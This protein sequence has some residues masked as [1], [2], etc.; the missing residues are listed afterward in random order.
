MAR[1]ARRLGMGAAGLLAVLPG[2]A[3]VA[4]TPYLRGT[5]AVNIGRA[6]AGVAF[7]RSLEASSLN[8][9]LLVTLQDE[10]SAYISMGMEMQASTSTL[11][12]NSSNLTTSDR[13]RFLPA[14]G[15]A[16]K[17][18]P[19]FALGLKLDTPVL[20]H[21]T[22]PASATS[23]FYG[24]GLDLGVHRLEF[25]GSWAIS[26]KFSVG[27]GLGLAR[28]SYASDVSVRTIVPQD[29]SKPY[30]AGTNPALALVE[31]S[32]N[33]SGSKTTGCFSLGFRYAIN[34][35]WTLGGSYSKILKADL[36]MSASKGRVGSTTALDGFGVPDA[37]ADAAAVQTV[38][39]ASRAV[40]GSGS[41]EIPG[42]A[43]L[44]VRHR[45]NRLLTW[46]LDLRYTQGA[47]L[48]LPSQ[49]G[50]LA[51]D[52]TL[53]K[54]PVLPD[55]NRNALGMSAMGEITFTKRLTGRLGV[56]L[57]AATVEEQAIN[58]VVGGSASASFSAGVGYQIWGGEL[59]LGA[60]FRQ[61][62][63][64]DSERLDLIWGLKNGQ[65]D[66]RSSGTKTRV[67]GS[68]FTWALGFRRSF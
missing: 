49:A 45:F 8:P 11:Q 14:V 36:S 38:L 55:G 58:P 42:V 32:L 27:A 68:G 37:G 67:E 3:L 57:D 22:I 26:E 19:A 13:T 60:Q 4:Q 50:L 16:W 15:L 66:V 1:T 17:V 29:P 51:S 64:V 62:K 5:D 63:D 24:E 59:S 30:D 2:A 6:G 56:A 54:A 31:Q 46:E 33:Q 53:V 18:T 35:R 34:P 7:G 44:G 10:R 65:P 52:G 12:S 61:S 20:R 23:R 39:A 40:A 47:S 9:A 48:K 28:I 43:T 25:Q 21:G 41:V